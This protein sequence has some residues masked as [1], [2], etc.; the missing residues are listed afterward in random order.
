MRVIV[1][2]DE[3]L[4]RESLS[5]LLS[6][7]P[8]VDII[9]SYS[10]GLE[11]L[12]NIKKLNPDVI[13][14][15]INMPQLDGFEVLELLGDEAPTIIFVTAYDE[16][17]VKAFEA[18][19]LDYLLKPVNPERLKKSVEKLK[20]QNKALAQNYKKIIKDHK[21]NFNINRVLVKDRSNVHVISIMEIL[22]FE[23]Q[24]DY[25]AIHTKDN[26][27]LKLDRLS[28]FEKSLDGRIFKRIHRS[29]IVN[30]DYVQ[31]IENQK[32]VVLN[33]GRKL[34]ISRSGYL[35]YFG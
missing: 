18:N 20:S 26:V 11:L 28:N 1:V 22:W 5:D 10:D 23:A 2:D 21:E 33:S 32:W 25:V 29:Y 31:R 35:R 24:D 15:D 30:M 4:A 7:Y 14:L 16:F 17:A 19:A 3:E 13:F 9:A 27:F 6:A 8:E 12:K 34:P